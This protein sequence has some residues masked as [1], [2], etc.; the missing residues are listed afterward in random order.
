MFMTS[1]ELYKSN[2][3]KNIFYMLINLYKELVVGNQN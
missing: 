1:Y 2:V 3:S